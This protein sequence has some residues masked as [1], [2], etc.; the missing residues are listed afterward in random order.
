MADHAHNPHADAGHAHDEH[1]GGLGKYLAVT[2]GLMV[3][4]F[5]SFSVANSPLMNTPAAGWSIMM[6][7]SCAKAL[8][9]IAFFMHLIWEANWKYVL[10]IPASIMSCF[11]VLML[12]P[13]IGFR[14]RHYSEER[15][16][17]AAPPVQLDHPRTHSG[18]QHGPLLPYNEADLEK[19]AHE[20][21]DHAEESPAH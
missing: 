15:L 2:A 7:V 1:H 11:L 4:T 16:Q 9:V 21:H 6:A 10:T 8:L 14:T 20:D 5:I 3:L 12:V 19:A 18:D 13:D 17:Y